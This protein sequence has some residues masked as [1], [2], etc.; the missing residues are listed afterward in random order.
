MSKTKR[1]CPRVDLRQQ[2]NRWLSL[3]PESH[4]VVAGGASLKEARQAAIRQGVHR[5]LLMMVPESTGF[6]VGFG[7]PLG[8]PGR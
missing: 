8:L 3:H 7:Q 4:A 2:T 6:F 1:L 5:P